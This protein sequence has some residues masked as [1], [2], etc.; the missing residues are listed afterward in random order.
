[1]KTFYSIISINIRP[2][3]N[4]RLSVGLIMIFGEKVF[5]RYSNSKLN[6]IQKLTGKEIWKATHNYLKLVQSSV[7]N[8]ALSTNKDLLNLKVENKYSRLFSEQYIEYLSRYN[9]NLVSFSKP[10]FIELEA[11]DQKLDV[12]S[13]KIVGKMKLKYLPSQLIL[14]KKDTQL[15]TILETYC[16]LSGRCQMPNNL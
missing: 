13:N 10:N 7:S 11:T 15:S 4:E 9:N 14:R 16:R 8:K 2:E 6:I 3:I 1:M 12:F 5:F